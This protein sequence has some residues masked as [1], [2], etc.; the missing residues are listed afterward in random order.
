MAFIYT[1]AQYKSRINAGIH[2]KIGMLVSDEDTMNEAARQVVADAH[3]RSDP[4]GTGID[5]AAAQRCPP[6]D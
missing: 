3:L 5:R 6:V 2:G 4:V 1:R